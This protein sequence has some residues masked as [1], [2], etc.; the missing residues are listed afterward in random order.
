MLESVYSESY[1][2]W[3]SLIHAVTYARPSSKRGLQEKTKRRE[4]M[5]TVEEKKISN[6]KL[7]RSW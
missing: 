2:R 7:H 5:E 6:K 1:S 3:F 4:K